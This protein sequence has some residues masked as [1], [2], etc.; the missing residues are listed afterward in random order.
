MLLDELGDRLPFRHSEKDVKPDDGEQSTE[1]NQN[2]G[3][4]TH[5]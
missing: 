4:I 2:Q 1:R 3:Q 5:G